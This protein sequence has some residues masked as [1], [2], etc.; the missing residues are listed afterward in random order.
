MNRNA[1]IM[2]AALI[3][4]SSPTWSEDCLYY[5]NACMCD[6]HHP[7]VCYGPYYALYCECDLPMLNPLTVT[8]HYPKF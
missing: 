2:L 7:G 1:S 8:L 6:N 3:G 5:G 4:F